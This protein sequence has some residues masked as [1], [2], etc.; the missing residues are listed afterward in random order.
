LIGI[1]SNSK[2]KG[3]GASISSTPL[4]KKFGIARKLLRYKQVQ[5]IGIGFESKFGGGGAWD[6]VLK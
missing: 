1:G 4:P 3:R 5:T 2:F 6:M